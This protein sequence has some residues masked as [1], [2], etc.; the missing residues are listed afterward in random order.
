[1]GIDV[2]ALN[3]LRFAARSG[4]L[5]E[6]ATLGRQNLKVS[7][8]RVQKLLNLPE[9]RDFGP[10]CDDLL[11]S[12]FGAS[13]VDSY[14]LSDFDG[15]SHIADLNH[16]LAVEATYDTVIDCGTL[17]H[18]LN[19]PQALQNISMMCRDGGRILHVSPSNNYC[20]HGFWQFS[21]E[22][23]YS[24]YSEA[25]GYIGTRVFL[26]AVSDA[27]H[28]YEVSMPR[29]G[30]RVDITSCT[31]LLVLAITRK[32]SSLSHSTVQQSDYV[33]EWSRGTPRVEPAPPAP[34]SRSGIR[35][36]L[37][38]TPL[39]PLARVIYDKLTAKTTLSSRNPRLRKW[40]TVDVV[41]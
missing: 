15:A 13:R 23:F 29:N 17:E 34:L 9:L 27:R 39:L 5:G 31:R 8:A 10:F 37:A 12:Q 21:P 35:D 16:P 36:M 26:A 11:V 22:L 40:R 41:G 24:L 19:V 28:W 14:D 3:L 4:D 32:Q 1:M 20:G 30:Q 18:I 25:N 38:E 6:V 2:H 7:P 33:F